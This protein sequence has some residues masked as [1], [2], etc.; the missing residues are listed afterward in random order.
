[1]RG[2]KKSR[3]IN[4]RRGILENG[5]FSRGLELIDPKDLPRGVLEEDGRS[6]VPGE[7]PSEV[8]FYWWISK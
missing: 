4:R 1:M 8:C 3:Y 6:E 2:G 5:V 7:G